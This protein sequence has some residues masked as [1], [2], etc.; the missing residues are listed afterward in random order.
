[1]MTMKHYT[2]S[3]LLLIAGSGCIVVYDN[4]HPRRRIVYRE[5]VAPSV[6]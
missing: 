1:M 5:E 6:A 2:L 4:P 3:A